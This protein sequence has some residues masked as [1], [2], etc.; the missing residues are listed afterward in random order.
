[1]VIIGSS[2]ALIRLYATGGYC[3]PRHALIVALPLLAASASGLRVMAAGLTRAFR[4]P[5][6]VFR[7]LPAAAALLIT[8][9]GLPTLTAAMNAGFGG[10]REAGVWLSW[11]VATGER[12]ADVTGWSLFYGGKPGYVF[13]DLHEASADRSLRWV[14]AREAH[15]RGP[16]GYCDRLRALVAGAKV[17]ARF[18]ADRRP[19]Q[20]QVTIYERP[21]AVP[22][23]TGS[24]ASVSTARR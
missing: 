12:V 21:E 20:S 24:G 10:Y 5:R 6:R 17:V 11:H 1:V 22:V 23:Q 13:A 19:W 9:P 2:L 3:T 8:A 7:A 18:P 14:V 16:W 4:R 15:L